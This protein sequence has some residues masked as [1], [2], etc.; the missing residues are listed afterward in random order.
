MVLLPIFRNRNLSY[1]KPFPDET[2]HYAH[3]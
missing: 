1:R 2:Y 3:R